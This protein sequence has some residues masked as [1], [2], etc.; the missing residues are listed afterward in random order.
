MVDRNAACGRPRSALSSALAF[1]SATWSKRATA[2]SWV[3]ASTSPRV[4]EGLCEP[5][6]DLSLRAKPIGRSRGRLDLA[7]SRSRP[8]PNSK[9][10]AEFMRS[11]MREGNLGS[12]K[13]RP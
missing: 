8:D 9:N 3:M 11:M 4:L 5:G 13:A 6:N 7:V 2:T 10:I 12:R 1:I